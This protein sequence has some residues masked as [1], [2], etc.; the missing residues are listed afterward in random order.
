MNKP[1]TLKLINHNGNDF[2][3]TASIPWGERETYGR[4]NEGDA[5]EKKHGNLTDLWMSLNYANAWNV[6]CF[7]YCTVSFFLTILPWYFEVPSN[8]S[9]FT[10]RTW[11][12]QLNIELPLDT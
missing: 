2:R 1:G 4:K 3:A 9:T 7:Y 8:V 11:T 6:V 12:S 5:D 10:N